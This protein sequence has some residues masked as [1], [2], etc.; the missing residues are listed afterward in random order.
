MALPEVGVSVVAKGADTASKQLSAFNRSVAST[1]TAVQKAASKSGIGQLDSAASNATGSVGGLSGAFGG[2]SGKLAVASVAFAGVTAAISKGI[3]LIKQVI[4]L[5]VNLAQQASTIESVGRAFG[6]IF[7]GAGDSNNI[8][9]ELRKQVKGTIS[10]VELMRLA[11]AGLQGT[12]Q[13]FRKIVG[14]QFG[15]ILDATQRVAQATGQSAEVVREKF[16]LG[17]RRQSKLLLDD[18]GVVVEA[19]KA[20]DAYAKQLGKSAS[21]LTDIEKRAAFAQEALRQ[22]NSISGELGERNTLADS[23]G[24]ISAAFQNI[25]DIYVTAVKPNFE[26]FFSIIARIATALQNAFREIAPIFREIAN[27]MSGLV[28]AAFSQFE[29][30][31]RNLEPLWN[32]LRVILPYIAALIRIVGNAFIEVVNI[33]GRLVQ[34][35]FA[36]FFGNLGTMSEK[37]FAAL[38]YR[39]A[40][41]AG[42]IVGAFAKGFADG[43]KYVLQAVTLIAQIVADFLEGFSPPKKGPLKDIDKGATRVAEAW[44]DGFAMMD[45]EPVDNVLA[46]VNA[47]LGDIGNFTREQVASRLEALDLAIRPFVEQLDIVKADFEAIAGFA[48]PALKAIDRQRSRLLQLAGKGSLIDINQ[49]R[50][51]DSQADILSNIRDTSQDAVDNAQI[52]LALASAQQAQERALLNIQKK[53]LGEA[54]KI[55]AESGSGATSPTTGGTGTPTATGETGA[56]IPIGGGMPDLIDSS[57]VDAAV[58]V[59]T[60]GFNQGL[61]DSGAIAAIEG[62]KAQLGALKQQTARIQKADPVAKL[63]KKFEGLKETLTKPFTDAQEIIDG[64]METLSTTFDAFGL[65]VDA[66]TVKFNLGLPTS[67]NIFKGGMDTNILP[68]FTEISNVI[69]G[70]LLPKLTSLSNFMGL[71]L[72]L[73]MGLFGAA[74]KLNIYDKMMD[75]V[76]LLT[77]T[78]FP[79]LDTF[80]NYMYALLPAD[81]ITFFDS[82]KLNIS[83]P[84]L[85]L[86]KTISDKV[87]QAFRR[88]ADYLNTTFKNI[89]TSLKDDVITPM[90]NAFGTLEDAVDDV[91]SAI[92]DMTSALSNIPDAVPDWMIPGSPTPFEIGL[93]GINSAMK[94]LRQT[95]L[96]PLTVEFAKLPTPEMILPQG[97][98]QYGYSNNG[99]GGTTIDNSH[100]ANL[101]GVSIQ[102]NSPQE[103]LWVKRQLL[104][105]YGV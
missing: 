102:V 49:L 86:E 93:R 81:F 97:S 30:A 105:Q 89:A 42:R 4:N 92:G 38:A 101:G 91:F 88:L 82:L 75:V 74:S 7:A 78:F 56:G 65:V 83:D 99:A 23:F 9:A 72:P 54:E 43:A 22:L 5:I 37:G 80:S 100:N 11:V 40:R 64:V 19:E 34:P 94:E 90:A 76:N 84:L 66:L 61:A 67:F 26:A 27:V 73:S 2:L 59:L 60:S 79:N 6:N 52:Q 31:L 96:K 20:Y 21:A 95:G 13:E 104:A 8:L 85:D 46:Q 3:G 77:G 14:S 44:A 28:L 103:A 70:T 16:L 55:T 45:L 53:R 68:K 36:Q 1:Q 71:T 47:R 35:I 24:Q 51:L 18:V 41:G 25:K 98:T 10:D 58:G 32:N 33:I 17:L 12:D 63:K 50:A 15:L 62:A 57:A 48:D 39:F 87:E 29:M 69:T